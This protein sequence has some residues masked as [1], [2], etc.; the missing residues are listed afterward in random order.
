MKDKGT[1]IDIARLLYERKA[2][3]I[4]VLNVA[5]LTVLTDYLVIASGY[6]ALQVKA[7]ADYLD[8]KLGMIGMDLRRIEGA[9][10][11]RWIV[12][13]YNNIIVHIFHQE[14]REYY[15]LDHL[16]SDGQNRLTLPF[17]DESADVA[18]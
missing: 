18:E 11:G 2:Q 14:D 6:N 16:W 5:H 8:E 12:M 1:A 17:V 3:G 10:D 9:S 7:L 15:R 4:T 13:D